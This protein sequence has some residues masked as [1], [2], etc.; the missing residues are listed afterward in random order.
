ME[1][2]KTRMIKPVK[3]T[4]SRRKEDSKAMNKVTMRDIA[5]KLGLSINTVSHALNDREDIAEATKAKVRQAAKE[6]GYKLNL[7]AKSLRQGLTR[8]V[9]VVASDA[10]DPYEGAVINRLKKL[11][12]KR[13]Y[14][15]MVFTAD[16][17]NKRTLDTITMRGVNGII[18]FLPPVNIDET[19]VDIPVLLLGGESAVS[20][21]DCVRVDFK[22][23]AATAAKDMNGKGFKK[24]LVVLNENDAGFDA[25][26]EGFESAFGGFVTVFVA[27]GE[28]TLDLYKDALKQCDC[29][30]CGSDKL[31]L[32]T[33][34]VIKSENIG[35][36]YT[37]GCGAAAA[38]IPLP[39]E[40]KSVGWDKDKLAGD[41]ADRLCAFMETGAIVSEAVPTLETQLR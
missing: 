28:I 30:F 13:E 7:S 41:A 1:V 36:I 15:L 38:E 27:D 33:L 35:N 9:G 19:N 37:V 4:V 17:F 23:A 29:V 32:Q 26:K 8:M 11:F 2:E 5:E 12:A 39:V 16:V 14:T 18:S 20:N 40:L 25:K 3:K 10:L 6:M 21:I 31:A 22:G 24:A 34:S